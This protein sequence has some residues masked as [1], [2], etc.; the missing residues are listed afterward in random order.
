[1]HGDSLV[2][3]LSKRRVVGR[4]HKQLKKIMLSTNFFYLFF[5]FFR[6]ASESL[7]AE[8][9]DAKVGSSTEA[10]RRV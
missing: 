10:Q 8:I 6:K 5:L 7:L 3:F 4:I 9:K 1:M 2:L